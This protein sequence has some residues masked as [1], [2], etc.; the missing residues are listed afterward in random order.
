MIDTGKSYRK[1][2]WLPAAE[3][4]AA[5]PQLLRNFMH[6]CRS[7]TEESNAADILNPDWLLVDRIIAK[8]EDCGAVQY[9]VKWRQ[10]GYAEATWEDECDLDA[11]QVGSDHASMHVAGAA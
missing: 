10:Q 5:K 3:L 4:M 6:S 11:D 9:L 2:A 1:T 8:R 7:E